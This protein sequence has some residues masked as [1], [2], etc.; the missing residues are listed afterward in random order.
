MASILT[1]LT[2][3]E[4]W[5]E[6]LQ[7]KIEKG[8]LS[9]R[10]EQAL[11]DFI[12]NKHYKSVTDQLQNPDY[13]FFPPTKCTINKSGTKKKRVIYMFENT[14]A[15]TLKVM[16]FLLYRYDH[17][18]SPNCYSFRQHSS[19]KDAIRTVLKTK[20]LDSM[21]C[22]K[23]DISNYFNSIP[24]D[25]LCQK[26][27]K[28]LS[29]DK[30]TYNF[31]K[32]LLLS[33]EAI[34]NGQLIKE[35]RG[36][37]AGTST[38]AFFANIYLKDLDDYFSQKGILYF[39]YSDDILMFFPT[40]KELNSEFT[41]LKNVLSH[42]GLQ[43]NPDKVSISAPNEPW[44]FLGIS[45]DNGIVD[46]S[47]VTINKLKAKIRRKGRA[48]YRWQKRRGAT[49]EQTAKVMIRV[50]NKKFYDETNE[51][52]FTWSRWFFP[53]VNTDISLKELDAYLIQYIRYLYKGRHYKGNFRIKYEDI[54]SLGYRSLVNEY[55]KSK[56]E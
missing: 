47:N 3:E 54:K 6:Y 18:I 29:D 14:E 53:L 23:V 11:S 26:L 36:A 48:L 45:Y 2:K 12:E 10:E 5:L 1:D 40:S 7:Y 22:L 34:E 39:R 8:H 41:Y 20:N 49:F 25:R 9:K 24:A 27:E 4:T 42:E 52:S 51:H 16:S 21:F 43:I 50:F 28:I 46:L 31:L 32:R 38:S 44:E 13:C 17:L 30:D 35:N 33:N 56:N 37:M 55:Y 19:A 15:M